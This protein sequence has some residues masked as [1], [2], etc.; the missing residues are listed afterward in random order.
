MERLYTQVPYGCRRSAAMP[1]CLGEVQMNTERR[2][3]P[4]SPVEQFSEVEPPALPAALS[5]EGQ[6]P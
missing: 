1:I 3:S 4:A 5:T 2:R 6:V